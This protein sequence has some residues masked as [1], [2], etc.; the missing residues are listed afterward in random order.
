MLRP[1]GEPVSGQREKVKRHRRKPE[2]AESEIL[3]AAEGFLKEQPFRE[4]TVDELM[5]RTGLARS[6]F[7]EHFRDRYHLMMRL[8]ERLGDLTYLASEPW[9][10]SGGDPIGELRKGI[11]DL[12]ALYAERGYLLRALADAAANDKDAAE[13]HRQLL[14]RFIHAVAARIREGVAAGEMR[15]TPA[16]EI[17]TA[18]TLMDESYL[19]QTLGRD[20]QTDPSTVIETLFLIWKR[21]LHQV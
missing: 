19:I 1:D 11:D 3:D 20:N 17:A 2:A 21:V 16:D 14:D 6:S 5:A 12:V 15:D 13:A 10:H 8:V 18:L 4:L 7:Y 9:F